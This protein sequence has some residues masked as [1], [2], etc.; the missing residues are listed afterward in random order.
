M[1]EALAAGPLHVFDRSNSITVKL[2]NGALSSV[3]ESE[4]LGGA[5]AA[6][7]GDPAGGWEIIQFAN[8]ELVAADTYRLTNLLRGQ[9]GSEPEIVASRPAGARFV[10]LNAAVVQ[11]QF[12]LA[13]ARQELTWRIGPAPYDLGRS[14]VSISHRG[15]MLG[16]RPLAPCHLRAAADGG[17]V[18][19][20]W[21]RRTR[22]DG[23]N[24]EL[25]EVPL[26]EESEAYR[27][28]VMDGATVKRSAKTG[29]PSYRY[30][31]ASIAAD[32]GAPPP[33][34]TLRIGQISAVYGRGA[35]L[36]RTIHV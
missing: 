21:I 11:P 29:A 35:N 10:L 31:A 5:N 8:A 23:D 18:V 6:A 26:G 4:L 28:E 24:W 34:F 7:I 27:V 20:T 22:S 30:A 16:L 25:E 3:S 36:E 14:H 17:D 19:F 12:A 2:E 13:E 32:F 9:A 33:A 15:K 1:L